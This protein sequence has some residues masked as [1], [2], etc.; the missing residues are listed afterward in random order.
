MNWFGLPLWAAQLIYYLIAGSVVFMGMKAEGIAQK[1]SVDLLLVIVAVMTA[2]TFLHPRNTLYIR[3][4]FI[5]IT[6]WLFTV[7]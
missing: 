6:C 2:G 5:S 3:P 7:W 1:Y 4:L